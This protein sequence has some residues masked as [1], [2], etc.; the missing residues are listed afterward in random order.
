MSGK[1]SA[2]LTTVVAEVLVAGVRLLAGTA[3]RYAGCT[4]ETLT[5]QSIFFS[6]HTSHLDFVVLW[7][8]LPRSVRG[9]TRPVAAADYW[10]GGVRRLLAKHVFRAVLV[11]RGVDA[12][13]AAAKAAN[14]EALRCALAAGESLIIFPE[15]TR[16][17]GVTVGPFRAGLYWL[18]KEWPRVQL[19]PV[20]LEN[21]N[22]IL[23]KG[24]MLPVPLL[25][26]LT[27]GPV[28]VLSDG[29]AKEDFLSRA[30]EAVMGDEVERCA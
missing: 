30:R 13:N 10:R 28:M 23:P 7:S 20:R 4:P 2:I 14:V 24:E 25:S 9:M 1:P 6:N 18:A 21:L 5:A 26:R 15:G 12:E 8:S 19:M 29:E 11:R 22:R 16:G 27:F 17:D 3:V